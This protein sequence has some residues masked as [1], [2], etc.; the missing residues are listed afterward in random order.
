M[1]AID[2]L[3]EMQSH[4]GVPWQSQRAGGDSDTVLAGDPNTEVTGVITSWSPTM[5]VLRKAIEAGH[6]AVVSRQ[7]PFYSHGEREP[8]AYRSGPAPSKQL[9]ESDSVYRAKMDLITQNKL[10]VLRFFDN[11]DAREIDGQLAGLAKALDWDRFHL[12]A[13]GDR[14]LY[15]PGDDLFQLPP[16]PLGELAKSMVA[17]LKAP[18]IRVM[19]RADA[20]VAKAALL[21]GLVLVPDLEAAL[22]KGPDLVVTGEVVEWEGAEYLQD[23]ITAGR[24]KGA[25]LLG[26]EVSEDPGSGE[27]AR[28]M[29]TFLKLPV[30]WIPTGTPFTRI[31]QE[32]A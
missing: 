19:G 18:A 31:P 25:I 29:Q 30:Q 20:R 22:A 28:W 10:V 26:S 16:V 24:V 2:L 27:V 4:L 6:N 12:A 1:T 32:G 21:P 9:L 17:Q 3:G 23:A 8:I 11:W 15:R 14:H 13:K 5:Q 7:S